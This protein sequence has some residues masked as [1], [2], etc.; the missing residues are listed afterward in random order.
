MKWYEKQLFFG[1]G[2]C[3]CE[4]IVRRNKD[5]IIEW[6]DHYNTMKVYDPCHDIT[7]IFHFTLHAECYEIDTIE[8]RV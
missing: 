5:N 6:L 4:N 8:G 1:Y 2:K 7:K 3:H